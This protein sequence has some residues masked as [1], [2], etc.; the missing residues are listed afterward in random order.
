MSVLCGGKE[1]VF[2]DSYWLVRHILSKDKG[3]CPRCGYHS[4]QHG[5]I[6]RERYYC[7]QCHLWE[8][9]WMRGGAE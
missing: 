2:K 7:S 8:P 9:S 1:S 3:V 5:F 4:F 6:P